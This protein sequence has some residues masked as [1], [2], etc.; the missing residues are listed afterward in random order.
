MIRGSAA[1]LGLTALTASCSAVVAIPFAVL[2]Q[3][4]PIMWVYV[5]ANVLVAVLAWWAHARSK[6]GRTWR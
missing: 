4:L 2:A 1:A 3:Q 5:V 6:Q